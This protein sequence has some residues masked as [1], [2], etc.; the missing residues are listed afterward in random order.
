MA[1]QISNKPSNNVPRK[2]R[3]TSLPYNLR[4]LAAN[5]CAHVKLIFYTFHVIP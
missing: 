3:F 2:Q 1:W 4:T 5:V